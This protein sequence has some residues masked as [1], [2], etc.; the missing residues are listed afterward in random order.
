[1]RREGGAVRV[2]VVRD[3]RPLFLFAVWRR[4][5]SGVVPLARREEGSTSDVTA[6]VQ[7][8]VTV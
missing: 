2:V 4:G 7:C 5:D 1:M 8:D 3:P 6:R